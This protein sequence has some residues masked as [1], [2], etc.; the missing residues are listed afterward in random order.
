MRPDS[1]QAHMVNDFAKIVGVPPGQLE[2]R[3]ENDAQFRLARRWRR[4]HPDRDTR[5]DVDRG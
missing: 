3:A 4:P 1:D 5:F 2:D